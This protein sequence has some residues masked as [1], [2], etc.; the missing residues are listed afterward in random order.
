MAGRQPAEHA[1]ALGEDVPEDG[2]NRQR[3]RQLVQA[4]PKPPQHPRLD[5]DVPS[6][7]VDV[8]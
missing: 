3:T 6:V 2:D 1:V 5:V 7:D 4:M 8:E